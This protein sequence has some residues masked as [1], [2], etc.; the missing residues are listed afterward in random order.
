MIGD[1][2]C[3]KDYQIFLGRLFKSKGYEVYTDKKIC[4]LPTF[5]GDKEKPDL[6]IFYKENK[7]EHQLISISNPFAI[8]IK[9]S[10]KF[11]DVSNA[12][13]QIKKYNGKEYFIN[14]W[15]GLLN[16]ILFS[17]DKCI[18]DGNCYE[19]VIANKCFNKGVNWALNHIL[20]SVSNSSGVV[21]QRDGELLVEFHNCC[22]SFNDKGIIDY[23]SK[24]NGFHPSFEFDG[25]CHS[26]NENGI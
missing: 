12:I 21:I 3:E 10:D 15:K 5:H 17:T 8:E 18:L 14:G 19:W 24:Y 2:K 20:F 11:N 23:P 13:L 16:T 25:E 26:K 6:L 9:K 22:F 1:F 7:R 4:E